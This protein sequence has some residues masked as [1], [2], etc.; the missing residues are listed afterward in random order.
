MGSSGSSTYKTNNIFFVP[1]DACLIFHENTLYLI[2]GATAKYLYAH[3]P[4]KVRTSIDPAYNLVLNYR[5]T[6]LVG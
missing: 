2:A 6:H 4:S 5:V 3:D 1:A